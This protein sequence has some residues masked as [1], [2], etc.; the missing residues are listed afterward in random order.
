MKHESELLGTCTT[1]GMVKDICCGTLRKSE[2]TYPENGK[3]YCYECCS[4]KESHALIDGLIGM[5]I[6]IPAKSA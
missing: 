6:L 2:M 3:N 1:C 4:G 5:G